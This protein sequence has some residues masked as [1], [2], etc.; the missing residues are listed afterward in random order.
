VRDRTF[1]DPNDEARGHGSMMR[2]RLPFEQSSPRGPAFQGV[3]WRD[4]AAFAAS[5]RGCMAGRCNESGECDWR[6][7]VLAAGAI[8]AVGLLAGV[9]VWRRRRRRV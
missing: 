4:P 6:E 7:S 9:V 5:A 1:P 2:A 8:G 3:R